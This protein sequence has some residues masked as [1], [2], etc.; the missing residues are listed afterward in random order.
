MVMVGTALVFR[1]P[2][3]C[4][5]AYAA[6]WT[7]LADPRTTPQRR[8]KLMGSFAVLGALIAAVMSAIAVPDSAPTAAAAALAVFLCMITVRAE[9]GNLGVLVS[10]VAVVAAEQPSPGL[11]AIRIAAFFL[12]GSVLAILLC[13]PCSFLGPRIAKCRTGELRPP[14]HADPHRLAHALLTAGAVLITY[15]VV[16]RL[17]IPN[18]QWATIAAVVV[19][20]PDERSSR[21]RTLERVAGS[22]IGGAAATGIT[23][24]VKDPWLLTMIL[25]PL[26]AAAIALRSVNY[27]LFV[28]F[29]TPL[30]V[31]V[32][33]IMAPGL[34][35]TTSSARAADNLLGSI[36]AWLGCALL[37][38]TKS[39]FPRIAKR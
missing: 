11:D 19:S 13:S 33:D 37:W 21:F 27:T 32:A 7:C 4:W 38:R 16:H 17:A 14:H 18:P 31:I 12:G 35:Y 3:L 20:K 29:L 6:F 9:F 39:I 26:A 22:I 25:F 23:L 24:L 2:E 15:F 1:E 28:C 34:A 36:L 8:F 10:V 30:F 5:A